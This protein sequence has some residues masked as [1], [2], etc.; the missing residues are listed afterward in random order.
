M[1]THSKPRGRPSF[2]RVPRFKTKHPRGVSFNG[3]GRACLCVC[4]HVCVF[5]CATEESGLSR[6]PPLLGPIHVDLFS[7]N[8][9]TKN[10]LDSYA[11]HGT[12]PCTNHTC[13]RVTHSVR[14]NN[15]TCS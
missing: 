13:T 9:D 6:D 2:P 11:C 1:A 12:Q 3:S 8:Q 10:F 7:A 4:A 5:G 15:R 14:R